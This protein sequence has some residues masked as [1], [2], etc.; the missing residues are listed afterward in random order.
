M[1]D[2]I[3]S[4]PLPCPFCG[5]EPTRSVNVQSTIS[6]RYECRHKSCDFQ[7][8]GPSTR[9]IRLPQHRW[10]CSDEQPSSELVEEAK[11]LWN[12][13]SLPAAT[14]VVVP[15]GTLLAVRDAL[16]A[17][18]YDEAYHRLYEAATESNVGLLKP[19]AAWEARA[20]LLAAEV[21]K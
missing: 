14:G 19:W 3:S 5:N 11:T 1:T 21:P 12:S 6:V 9:G 15:V 4:D 18:N 13:R 10:Y 8:T 2:L 20:A 16:V 17:K 7:P